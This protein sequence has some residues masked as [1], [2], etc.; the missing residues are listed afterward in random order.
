M[1]RS[2]LAI[3]ALAVCASSCL[4]NE[5]EITVREDGSVSV[6]M[7]AKGK[8]EDLADGYPI[9][10]D[11]PWIGDSDATSMWVRAV[12][13]DTGSAGVRESLGRLAAGSSK[14]NPDE[15]FTLAV[16]ADFSSVNDIPRWIAPQAE[17]YRTAYLERS[18][19]LRVETKSGRRVY[20]FERIFHARNFDRF[21][22]WKS[23][24]L[25]IPKEL[26]EKLDRI[27]HDDSVELTPKERDQLI[28]V[29]T[30]TLIDT[31][32]PYAE[33][34]LLSV[35]T[36]GDAS[37]DPR[38]VERVLQS[39]REAL[40]D[41]VRRERMAA[42]VDKVLS[43]ST[44]DGANDETFVHDVER[45]ESESRDTLRASLDAALTRDGVPLATRNAIRGQLE[46]K[47][48]AFD[49]TTDLGD[50]GF[51]VTVHMPGIVVG[52]NFDERNGA[53]VVW[54]FDGEGLNDRDRVLRVV[55][56][57]D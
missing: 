30:A 55:S 26:K 41:V 56:V 48:T 22:F 37:L 5:E 42:I 8:P 34:S 13:G 46:W 10:L 33:S 40:S 43:E 38:S 53:S 12:G 7:S 27:D 2:L 9:P 49:H 51:T 21:S 23:V 32:I 17:P 4:E 31:S 47:F 11:S 39:V 25:R 44:S 35:F 20:S 19:D 52:G 50:E 6:R 14:I 16:R 57:L 18:A 36:A 24:E 15:D 54:N 3:C 28:D 29:M 1:N 45:L